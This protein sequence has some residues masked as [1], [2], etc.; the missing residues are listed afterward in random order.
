MNF[1]ENPDWFNRP[2]PFAY[3]LEYIVFIVLAIAF[4]FVFPVLLRKKDSKT[5]KTVLIVLWSIAVFL[6]LLKYGYPRAKEH[7]GAFSFIPLYRIPYN[8]GKSY[9]FM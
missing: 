8:I 1:F 2:G 7:R 9:I 3:N 5:I 4:A 6:D